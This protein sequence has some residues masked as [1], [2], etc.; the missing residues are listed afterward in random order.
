MTAAETHSIPANPDS[1]LYK[2]ASQHA[3][4]EP[5][6]LEFTLEHEGE[7]YTAQVYAKGIVYAPAGQPDQVAHVE[8]QG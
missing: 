4:G 5:V 7:A 3:L 8:S 2:Y 6:S 1:A